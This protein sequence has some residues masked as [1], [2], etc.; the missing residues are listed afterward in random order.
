MTTLTPA[1]IDQE[2]IQAEAQKAAFFHEDIN[3]A[4]PYPFGSLAAQVFRAAFEKARQLQNYGS[5]AT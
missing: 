3:D 4:C 1:R 2:A 5:T